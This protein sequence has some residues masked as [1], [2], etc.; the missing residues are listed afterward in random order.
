MKLST[1]SVCFY[2]TIKQHDE[3]FFMAEAVKQEMKHATDLKYAI[4][5]E[6][7]CRTGTVCTSSVSEEQRNCQ[8]HSL[9]S[10]TH[11]GPFIRYSHGQTIT[12]ESSRQGLVA[13]LV[14]TREPG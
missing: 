3:S 2:F 8:C 1:V 11:T 4:D 10:R 5:A 12:A 7:S 6:V 14:A 9:A 13:K